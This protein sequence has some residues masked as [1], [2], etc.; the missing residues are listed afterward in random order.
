MRVESVVEIINEFNSTDINYLEFKSKDTTII[1][2]KSTEDEGV[3]LRNMAM[4]EVA[5][6]ICKDEEYVEVTSKYVSLIEIVNPFNQEPFVNLN[7]NVKKGSILGIIKYLNVEIELVSPV[8]GVM[9]EI[10]IRNNEFV[11]Y[12][13]ELFIIKENVQ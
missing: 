2:K 9:K 4:K 10:C 11:E 3:K 7:D 13:Q 8:D 12:G 1:M 5:G 6:T